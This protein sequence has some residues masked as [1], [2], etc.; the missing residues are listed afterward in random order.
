MCKGEAIVALV[1]FVGPFDSSVR[2]GDVITTLIPSP[3]TYF[4][5]HFRKDRHS[6]PLLIHR[7]VLDVVD[8]V[9]SV[10]ACSYVSHP[11]AKPL[12]VTMGVAIIFQ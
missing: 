11:K 5:L 10:L 4:I 1:F 9:K 2:V 6:H 3:L 7:C 12:T 8:Y